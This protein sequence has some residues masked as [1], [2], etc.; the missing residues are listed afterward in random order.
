VVS[1]PDGKVAEIYL[2]IAS[3]LTQQLAE[4]GPA[5][6]GPSISISDD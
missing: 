3:K 1:D 6:G 2:E 5:S 4:T